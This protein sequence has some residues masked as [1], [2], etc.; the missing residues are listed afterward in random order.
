[1]REEDR[2]PFAALVSGVLGVYEKAATPLVLSVWWEAMQPFDFEAV[3][4]AMNRHAVNPDN[5]QFAPKPA[6]IVRLLRGSSQDAALV[7]WSKVDRA[8]RSVGP[9]RSVVFDDPLIH[10]VIADM[11]GWPD[12]ARSTD[13]EWPFVAKQFENRYRGATRVADLAY[14]KHLPGLAERHNG[15][16]G[17]VVEPPLLLG[18]PEKAA[19]VL[20][21]G[22]EGSRLRIT[23]HLA[24]LPESVQA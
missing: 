9:Y 5:G 24:A 6:D 7:A 17:R 20:A 18:D 2:K 15:V 22:A 12:L 4:D 21:S 8:V 13:D 10:V 1:M 16:E 23:E 11:G 19:R 14:P 3:R